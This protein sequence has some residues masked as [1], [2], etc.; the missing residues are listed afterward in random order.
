MLSLT[1]ENLCSVTWSSIIGF[2][3]LISGMMIAKKRDLV[4]ADDIAGKPPTELSFSHKLFEGKHAKDLVMP[5]I[6]T[7]VAAGR[8]LKVAPL[9][10][11]VQSDILKGLY[12]E[13]VVLKEIVETSSRMKTVCEKLIKVMIHSLDTD[14]ASSSQPSQDGSPAN[15]GHDDEEEDDDGSDSEG[16]EDQGDDDSTE[17]HTL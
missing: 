8:T 1:L 7:S 5:S 4:R 6:T 15:N 2:P 11:E 10:E 13:V 16:F 12:E 9:S 14:G 17:N 3:S